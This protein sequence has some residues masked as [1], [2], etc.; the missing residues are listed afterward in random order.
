VHDFG[1]FDEPDDDV[2]LERETLRWLAQ[3]ADATGATRDAAV[4]AILDEMNRLL[5]R[6]RRERS[7]LQAEYGPRLRTLTEQLPVMLWMT[8][9][10]LRVTTF[11]GAGLAAVGIDPA[12]T[13]SLALTVVLGTDTSSLGAMEAHA[14]A[15]Q[16]QPAVFEYEQR[17]RSY[18][19]HVQPLSH[20]DGVIV[21]TM[22]F[23]I[24]VT[25]RKQAEEALARREAQLAAAQRLADVGSWEHD[26]AA[27]RLTWL[28]ELS[29]IFGLEPHAMPA[30]F[31]P[32]LEHVHPDDA[33]RVR[34][35]VEAAIRSGQSFEYQARIV[36]PNGKVRHYHSRGTVLRDAFGRPSRV[37]GAG[38]DVTD[39]VRAE[40]ARAFQ[41]QSRGH[42]EGM[43]FV[44][45]GLAHHVTVDFEAPNGDV[46]GPGSTVPSSRAEARREEALSKLL[47]DIADLRRPIPSE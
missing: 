32:F 5:L 1:T 12:S 14:Q 10:E 47:D 27:D 16:G 4:A 13:V 22:G 35:I 21:G 37:V 26:V 23:A 44:I 42:P 41:W 24:D 30:S 46:P 29:R 2:R 34:A 18:L 7:I 9:T 31:E 25:E 38:Q 36:R 3:Y 11:A 8:D 39:R 20:P 17:S 15:L 43:L 45:R 28:D 19:A 40:S 6:Y 33:P